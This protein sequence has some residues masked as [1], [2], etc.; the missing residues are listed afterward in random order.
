MRGA[1]A[2][3]A[4]AALALAAPAPAQDGWQSIRE[5]AIRVT[6][7]DRASVR[8]SIDFSPHER[9]VEML[10][11]EQ[12][13]GFTFELQ[14]IVGRPWWPDLEYSVLR[15]EAGLDYDNVLDSYQVVTFNGEERTAAD[16]GE[17]VRVIGDV[18]GIEM[19][20]EGLGDALKLSKAT[21]QGRFEVDVERLPPPLQIEMLSTMDW[22]FTT[23]W[24]E[25]V[26]RDVLER[27]Q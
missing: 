12:G 21:V 20:G 19:I 16:L 6:G 13:L 22:D 4:L 11:N 24:Q 3:C 10:R 25:W 26:A 5:V 9:I 27:A 8:A 2:A 1:C 17:A 23:G 7:P 18:H 15:W 14:V